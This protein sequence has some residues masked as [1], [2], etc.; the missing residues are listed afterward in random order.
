MSQHDKISDGD[1]A[2]RYSFIGR[3]RARYSQVKNWCVP[4]STYPRNRKSR[5]L[6]L[7][8]FNVIIALLP[9]LF[10][11]LIFL[12]TV[13]T[14]VMDASAKLMMILFLWSMVAASFTSLVLLRVGKVKLSRAVFGG[15]AIMV[16]LILIQ[17]TGGI[18]KS[19]AASF[20]VVPPIIFFYF[21][22]LRAG[23]LATVVFPPLLF[24]IELINLS[25]GQPIPDL[26]SRADP[27]FNRLLVTATLYMIVT[28]GL[29]SL[30]RTISS[31]QSEFFGEHQELSSLV[32]QDTLTGIA[33]SRK[34][35]HKLQ[36]DCDIV[37]EKGG[38]LAV[39]YIDLDDFKPINDSYGHAAGDEMLVQIAAR[40]NDLCSKGDCA[41]RMGGD[42][43]AIILNRSL[44]EDQA[45]ILAQLIE[46]TVSVP[47]YFRNK[48]IQ[49]S[50][51]VGYCLYPKHTRNRGGIIPLAD[52]NMYSRKSGNRGE[53][54]A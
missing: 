26:T 22:S 49:V 40:L 39:Y 54:A 44:D 23:I 45:R 19:V 1:S 34:L 14:S 32:D 3:L 35:K 7:I 13:S 17:T 53:L 2:F 30:F 33:N 36:R 29:C 4:L 8:L 11:F 47:V 28:L 31:R 50:A 16:A 25:L 42:E 46:T 10:L 21:Y 51:S 48:M 15:T 52:K 24:A 18:S 43:F 5:T 37:D 20:I 9:S 38:G 6:A 41:A 12:A 27:N